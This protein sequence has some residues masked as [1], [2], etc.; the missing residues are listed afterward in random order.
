MVEQENGKGLADPVEMKGDW[1]RR[2]AIV[3]GA[4]FIIDL[5]MN[6]I[7]STLVEVIIDGPDYLVK[8]SEHQGQ[9][10]TGVLLEAIS[11][12][13]LV[14]IG[15]MVY[16]VLKRQSTTIAHGYLG[17][18]VVE[19]VIA[20]TFVISH[21][22]LLGLSQEYVGADAPDASHY[23]TI[24]TLLIKGHDFAYQVY[25]IFYSLGCLMLFGLMFRARLVPRFISIWGLI[26]VVVAV[27]GLVADL[28]G[29]DVGMETYA[30]PLGLCQIFLAI[31][32][33]AKGF[34]PSAIASETSGI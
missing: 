10:I 11:V 27:S 34:G 20:A 1:T 30:M 14:T 3:V 16:P 22:M 33:I 13:C 5:V 26:G 4:L 29:A 9:V 23:Q 8:L 28:Y 6:G 21:L 18:R 7:G 31:W 12:V 2:I 15:F 25:L 32:L 17:V 24:G 19:T